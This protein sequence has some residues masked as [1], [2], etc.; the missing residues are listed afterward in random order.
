MKLGNI[1][2]L[3]KKKNKSPVPSLPAKM[4]ILLILAKISSKAVIKLSCGSHFRMKTRVT[5]NYFVSDCCWKHFFACNLPQ[6]P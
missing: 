6:F 5:L 4:E 2:K 1:M 3:K